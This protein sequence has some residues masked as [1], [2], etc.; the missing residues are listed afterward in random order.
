M[1]FS[2]LFSFLQT[3]ALFFSFATSEKQD[4]SIVSCVLKAKQPSA[5]YSS[6]RVLKYF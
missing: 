6:R 2:A 5:L 3:Y 4:D 1:F